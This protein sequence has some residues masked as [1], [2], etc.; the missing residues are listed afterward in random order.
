MVYSEMQK[1][2]MSSLNY[3]SLMVLGD[4]KMMISLHNWEQKYLILGI[5]EM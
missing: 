4:A 5:T 3:D 1:K 2:M